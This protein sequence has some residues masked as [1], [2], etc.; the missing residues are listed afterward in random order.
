MKTFVRSLPGK[1]LL[2]LLCLLS[3][4]TAIG[5]G[6]GIFALG[7]GR[8]YTKTES[9]ML[10]DVERNLLYSA[11][12]DVLYSM[13][14]RAGQ[15]QT[16]REVPEDS[17]V[18]LKIT[19]ASG[20]VVVCDGG[21]DSLAGSIR[22][23]V[24]CLVL[25]QNNAAVYYF[26]RYGDYYSPSYGY[27]APDEME[28]LASAAPYSAEFALKAELKG[29]DQF[30]V[31]ARMVHWA[32]SLRYTIF[33]ICGLAL[34]L[35]VL[36][37]VALLTVSGRRPNR[38]EVLPGPLFRVPFDLLSAVTIA[39][40]ILLVAALAVMASDSMAEIAVIMGAVL[41]FTALFLGL[42]MSAAAR[43]KKRMLVRGSL[44][45]ILCRFFWRLCRLLVR[46]LAGLI[47]GLPLVWRT[48]VLLV[49][50]S[51]LELLCIAGFWGW[52]WESLLGLWFLEKLIVLP[53]GLYF[54]F[55]LR[56][57]QQGGRM[58]ASGN[59]DY[60]TNT[61]GMIWDLK[62]SAQDLNNIAVGMSTAVDQRLKSER[63]KTEL[64]TNV[65][66]DIKTPLTSIINYAGLI[67]QEPCENP[68]IKEYTEVLSRQSVRLKRLL[69]DLVEASKASSGNLEVNL[70]LCNAAVLVSQA[71][72][73]FEGKL[74]EAGLT[75]VT[76]VPDTPVHIMADG[77]RLWR[78]FDNLLNN[79]RK[80]ALSGTRVYLNLE[81]IGQRAVI[82]LKNISREPLNVSAE[83]LMERFVRGDQSRNTEG[84]GL[85]LSIARSL[86]ELQGGSL[87][88]SV[89]G[90]LFKAMVSF[91]VAEAGTDK[92]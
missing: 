48:S 59:L 85:G 23:K 39:A 54:A 15:D 20:T 38:E 45:A 60:V 1:L 65:S 62:Q 28:E 55:M 84:N 40:G 21:Y 34:L 33:I 16:H 52:G 7:Q 12:D 61:Q 73:E 13:E 24:D 66:H 51:L 26:E 82:T 89:D 90:D 6:I 83:E 25:G 77:R 53:L 50:I 92:A 8:I 69:E 86:T 63:M 70:A 72:G 64:I 19:D 57:L 32:Y 11:M 87:V 9:M 4:A 78:V 74:S 30:A 41:L 67:E 37:Y 58:L 71:A 47:R 2:Y 5:S 56:R 80:Y 76:S 35:G 10:E 3:L 91:P 14:S 79:A 68:K 46:G 27:A 36:T 81:Q 44:L 49:G 31:A 75:L 88:L 42:S 43:I 17:N 22:I 18:L 29:Q